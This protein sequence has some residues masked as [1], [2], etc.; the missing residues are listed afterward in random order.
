VFEV[1]RAVA[2]LAAHLDR[3]HNQRDKL[4]PN[5]IAN[6]ETG[7]PLTA[8]DAA[9]GALAHSALYQRFLGFMADFDLLVC[10]T[11]GVVPFP[12]EQLYKTE[13]EGRKT[14]SYVHWLACTYGITLTTHPAISVPAG[15]DPTGTPFGLQLVGRYGQDRRLLEVARAVES[16]LAGDPVTARPVPDL[17]KLA[18]T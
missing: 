16:R 9:R 11:V 5:I 12:V 15:L 3:Y 1:M 2:F 7:L 10:P 18:R 4:G 17:A 13:I 14:R 8:A 6:V